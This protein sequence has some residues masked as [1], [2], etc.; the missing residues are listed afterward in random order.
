[1]ENTEQKK[2]R[3]EGKL[4]QKLFDHCIKQYKDL[5]EIRTAYIV[6]NKVFGIDYISKN[7]TRF[8]AS[9]TYKAELIIHFK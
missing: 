3:K 2:Q 8:Y 1:M 7:G 4:Y 6:E 5:K 9:N